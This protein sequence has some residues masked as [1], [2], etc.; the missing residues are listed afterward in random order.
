MP[1]EIDNHQYEIVFATD[2]SGIKAKQRAMM[3]INALDTPGP[4]PFLI[5]SRW[6][7]TAKVT[8]TMYRN[9]M[10]LEVL[11]YFLRVVEEE[12]AKWPLWDIN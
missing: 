6:N 3:E 11:N 10:P 5:A 9:D 8:I 4:N 1:I 12:F 7:E 2:L